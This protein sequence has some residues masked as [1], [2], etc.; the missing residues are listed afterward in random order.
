MSFP[1]GNW[2]SNRNKL[3]SIT[4][5]RFSFTHMRMNF[6]TIWLE[7][8]TGDFPGH[9]I[10][11]VDTLIIWLFWITRSF[12]ITSKRYIHPADCWESQQ[13]RSPGKLPWSHIHHRHWRWTFNQALW[14]TWWFWLPNCQFFT[15]FSNI[16]YGPSYGIYI[17]Q[18]IRYVRC[19]SHYDDFRY[20]HKYLVDCL[21]SQG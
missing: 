1:S 2:N 8:A 18:L 5:W 6:S 9:L 13:I 3:R 19:C 21:L 16:P 15:P 14:Q 10:Y 12:W 4:C 17:S 11:A 7:T 20:R